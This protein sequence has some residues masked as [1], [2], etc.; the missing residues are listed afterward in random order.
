MFVTCSPYLKEST[1]KNPNKN[2]V[3]IKKNYIQAIPTK[4]S[5]FILIIRE[6][7]LFEDKVERKL[8]IIKLETHPSENRV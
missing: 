1:T 3:Q 8:I 4:S 6:L 2:E 7:K 5:K